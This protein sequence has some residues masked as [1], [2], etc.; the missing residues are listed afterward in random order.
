MLVKRFS[1]CGKWLVGFPR[2]VG[3]NELLIHRVL[4]GSHDLLVL[5]SC[6]P[7]PPHTHPLAARL[8]PPGLAFVPA[9]HH[10]PLHVATALLLTPN[11]AT[12]SRQDPPKSVWRRFF[13]PAY[14]IPFE[15][16]SFLN[17]DL[18]LFTENCRHVIVASCATVRPAPVA[19]QRDPAQRAAPATVPLRAD[20]VPCPP[21]SVSQRPPNH[22]PHHP[23][24]GVEDIRRV[25]HLEDIRF[26]VIDL[27]TGMIADAVR[28]YFS[29]SR[30]RVQKTQKNKGGDK[31]AP[32][33][34]AGL[35]ACFLTS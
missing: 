10:A 26:Y 15:M 18:C 13:K 24:A 34:A 8:A 4:D 20:P 2:V 31:A 16:P 7:A 29:C 19:G 14:R 32:A 25:R 11:R 27:R 1:P 35:P 17:R 28:S 21:L 3:A 5:P 30:G 12:R 6:S 22:S 23:Q 9:S 33:A